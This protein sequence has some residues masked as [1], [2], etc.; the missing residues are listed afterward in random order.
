M[1]RPQVLPAPY[2]F[3]NAVQTFT[4]IITIPPLP[5]TTIP[6]LPIITISPLPIITIP[7]LQSGAIS[8]GGGEGAA[9]L[10]KIMGITQAG[11]LSNMAAFV[12][13][14]CPTRCDDY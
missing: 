2:A 13:T 10:N 12:P 7:P 14:D 5:I 8:F 6:P 11:Q 4:P 3:S 9:L 1:H